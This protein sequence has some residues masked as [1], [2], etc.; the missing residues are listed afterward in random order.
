MHL[1]QTHQSL[2]VLELALASEAL[3]YFPWWLYGI[4]GIEREEMQR[5]RQ[6]IMSYQVVKIRMLF[7][8]DPWHRSRLTR[9]HKRWMGTTTHYQQR[10]NLKSY[11][12]N[13]QGTYGNKNKLLD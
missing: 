11:Q 8:Q 1:L 5:R 2:W 9:H 6:T 10:D 7:T 13:I 3:S 12:V 4:Y